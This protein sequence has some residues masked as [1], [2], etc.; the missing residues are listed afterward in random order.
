MKFDQLFTDIS[1][2]TQFGYVMRSMI[3]IP[4]TNNLRH[5]GMVHYCWESG[6]KVSCL[7]GIIIVKASKITRYHTDKQK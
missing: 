7:L 5:T 4:G 2:N 6:L 3:T 1:G